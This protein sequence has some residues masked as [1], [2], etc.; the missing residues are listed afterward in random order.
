MSLSLKT[1]QVMIATFWL[2]F[3]VWKEKM[4]HYYISAHTSVRHSVRWKFQLV[5]ALIAAIWAWR[6][7]GPKWTIKKGFH[8]NFSR[9]PKIQRLK[10]KVIRRSVSFWGRKSICHQFVCSAKV[11]TSVFYL[12]MD[13]R[14]LRLPSS[15]SI[16]GVDVE[17]VVRAW[18]GARVHVDFHGRAVN[19]TSS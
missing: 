6:S 8:T 15:K 9:L 3:N 14:F 12:H 11:L 16:R 7:S 19:W 18:C 5:S 2:K 4:K 10:A 13:M 1:G 17:Y